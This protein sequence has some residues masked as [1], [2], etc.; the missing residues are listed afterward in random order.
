MPIAPL[1]LVRDRIT[2][3][4]LAVLAKA[5]FGDMVKAVVDVDRQCMAVG[6][7]LHADEEAVLLDDGSTQSSLWGINVYPGEQGEDF[8][9]FDSMINVRP[10]QANPSRSVVDAS[11]R[12]TIRAVVTQLVAE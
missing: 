4:E 7:E 12:S 1:R 2:R 10:A 9:E 11:I 5:G 3:A 6:G 8:I